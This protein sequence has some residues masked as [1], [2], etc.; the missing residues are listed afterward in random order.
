M[1][2]PN[3]GSYLPTGG[4]QGNSKKDNKS[5]ENQDVPPLPPQPPPPPPSSS[6]TK[7]Y[8]DALKSS[9]QASKKMKMAPGKPLS[10]NRGW[11]YVLS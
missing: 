10:N 8:A 2:Q 6:S 9:D 11:F 4:E 1:Y 5:A 7:S 3:N